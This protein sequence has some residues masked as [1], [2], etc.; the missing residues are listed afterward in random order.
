MARYIGGVAITGFISP[1]DTA[2]VF[3]THKAMFGH[4]G[5]RS[6]LDLT[7]RDAIT[8]PRREEGMIVYVISEKK[9]YRLVGGITNLHWEEIIISS[10]GNGTAPSINCCENYKILNDITERDNLLFSDRKEGMVVYI[11]SENKEYRLVGGSDNINW[12]LISN[13][14]TSTLSD[15]NYIIVNDL[16]ERD[17]LS[18]DKRKEGI[19]VYVI[20]ENK[21]YRLVG[22]ILNSNWVD[23]SII[24]N[25]MAKPSYVIVENISEVENYPMSERFI[26]LTLYSKYEDKEFRL[27]KGI[28]NSHYKEINSTL[29]NYNPIT[30][31]I[32]NPDG[33]TTIIGKPNSSGSGTIN[34]G[35]TTIEINNNFLN[36]FG[37]L[38]KSNITKIL[39]DLNTN[40]NY[41]D[42]ITGNTVVSNQD[43]N[44]FTFNISKPENWVE[45]WVFFKGTTKF[46][47]GKNSEI[48]LEIN[49]DDTTSFFN[50]L[51]I[52]KGNHPTPPNLQIF[53]NVNNWKGYYKGTKIGKHELKVIQNTDTIKIGSIYKNIY[54]F[55]PNFII[56][57]EGSILPKNINIDSI[58]IEKKYEVKV[59][60]N[61]NLNIAL[62]KV[63]TTSLGIDAL[64]F[65]V[66]SNTRQFFTNN[67]EYIL[68]KNIIETLIEGTYALVVSGSD[69]GVTIPTYFYGPFIIREKSTNINENDALLSLTSNLN[70]RLLSLPITTTP[71]MT[72]A[73]SFL[74]IIPNTN[75]ANTNLNIVLEF[76]N[77]LNLT[78]DPIYD[79]AILS[80]LSSLDLTGLDENNIMSY[81][82]IIY[83]ELMK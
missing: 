45:D 38:N 48:I 50:I 22:G 52:L 7:A 21:E 81:V 20:S 70:T 2:D 63:Q 5:Y 32:T 49:I 37:C 18:I 76:I 17:N 44:E 35:G 14:S 51:E 6:V 27:V 19:I 16:N 69:G 9:E 66:V 77:I 57:D 39:L 24:L 28:E 64:N 65:S 79:S 46:E 29:I 40:T 73:E 15:S 26:G 56:L 61:S 59:I 13:N 47:A 68:P 31:E 62:A 41:F 72:I 25:A 78:F 36:K 71:S 30:G 43:L 12:T 75:F 60:P 80:I 67:G 54:F 1:T 58:G 11:I 53:G 83:N 3:A 74:T 33:S 23:L 42:P 34:N 82:N 8:N 55:S 4:G 10:G